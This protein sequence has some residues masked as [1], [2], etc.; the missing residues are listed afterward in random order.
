[1]ARIEVDDKHVVAFKQLWYL[2]VVTG[3]EQKM[4]LGKEK[5][6]SIN[7]NT[8][9]DAVG[10][11]KEEYLED[12]NRFKNLVATIRLIGIF[13]AE[14]FS[15]LNRTAINIFERLR[16]EDIVTEIK[17]VGNFFNDARIDLN[18]PVIG[19]YVYFDKEKV[20]LWLKD[21]AETVKLETLLELEVKKEEEV[22]H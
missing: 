13:Y 14:P 8:P 2:A 16:K 18:Q 4:H 6:V 12:I 1:M 21:A 9:P 5:V 22:V 17:Y 15:F 10:I 20:E 19:G 11:K 7:V 3:T